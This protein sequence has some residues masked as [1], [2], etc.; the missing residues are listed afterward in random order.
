MM[1]A[2]ENLGGNRLVTREVVII[3]CNFSIRGNVLFQ[4]FVFQIISSTL[5]KLVLHV[6]KVLLQLPMLANLT[7]LLVIIPCR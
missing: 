6:L 3:M 5:K 1:Y 7:S 2:N 4:V